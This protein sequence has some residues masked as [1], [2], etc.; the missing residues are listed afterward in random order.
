MGGISIFIVIHFTC[1]LARI[2]LNSLAGLFCSAIIFFNP[3]LWLLS[4][5]YMPDIFGAAIMVATLYFLTLYKDFNYRLMIGAF[6]T[7]ILA[8][9]RLSYL[10]VLIVPAALAVYN[11]ETRIYFLY[12]FVIGII[13]WLLPFIWVTGWDDLL[14]AASNQTI[15]HFTDFG[16]T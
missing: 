16:G 12:S 11:S 10:P 4:N 8:G 1:K 3:L 2:E 15:G 13:V 6:L 5:R 14:L 9:T 7:G